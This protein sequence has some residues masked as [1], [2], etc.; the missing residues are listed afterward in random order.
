MELDISVHIQLSY[1]SKKIKCIVFDNLSYGHRE[2]IKDCELIV[3]DLLDKDAVKKVCEEH[4]IDGVIHFAAFA[5]VGESVQ[6]PDKYYQNNVVGTLNLLDAL[7]EK[8][9]KNIVFSSTC[10]T[11]GDAEIASGN[12]LYM[13]ENY[14]KQGDWP[15][16]SPSLSARIVEGKLEKIKLIYTN[17]NTLA[18]KHI[19]RNRFIKNNQIEFLQGSLHEDQSFITKAFALADRMQSLLQNPPTIIIE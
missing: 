1:F 10:A 16:Y 8:N 5:Y 19:Y 17:C 3:G 6:K 7:L 12:K 4:Q 9:V 18:C 11:Y 2:A 13:G 15:K 14:L